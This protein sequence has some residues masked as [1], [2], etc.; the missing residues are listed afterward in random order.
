M[1]IK[2]LISILFLIP[3]LSGARQVQD[4]TRGFS[5]EKI[6]E[7]LQ[8]RDFAYVHADSNPDQTWLEALMSF[9]INLVDGYGGGDALAVIL[10]VI[11]YLLIFFVL[12]LIIFNITNLSFR[13]LFFRSRR[14]DSVWEPLYNKQ[15]LHQINYDDLWKEAVANGHYNLAVRYHFRKILQKLSKGGYIAWKPHKRNI[16]YYFEIKHAAVKSDFKRVYRDFEYVWYGEFQ[17]DKTIYNRISDHFSK[18]EERITF[19]RK[20]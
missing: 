4:S 3:V 16:D 14:K 12:L 8:H 6:E 5:D 2:I 13:K 17:I 19:D 9:L 11:L 15:Q 7:Y 18:L 1:K 10:E 20:N